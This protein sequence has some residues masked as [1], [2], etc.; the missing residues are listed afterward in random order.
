MAFMETEQV[1]A[2]VILIIGVLLILGEALSPGAF[3]VIP[4][5]SLTIVGIIGYIF[6]GFLF[7]IA[8]PIVAIV[9]AL[10]V[11]LITIKAYQLLSKPAPPTTTVNESLKGKIGTVVRTTNPDDIKG[12]VKVGSDTW[13]ATSDVP[14]EKGTEVIVVDAEGVHLIVV[15]KE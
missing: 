11:T 2:L 6:P 7:S 14:I 3:L 15:K 9:I 12:K 4:G 13:S 8:S 1:V 5:T 10:P